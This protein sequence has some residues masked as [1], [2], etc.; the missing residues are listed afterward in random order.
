MDG[1]NEPYGGKNSDKGE[2]RGRDCSASSSHD[3]RQFRIFRGEFHG[4]SISQAILFTLVITGAVKGLPVNLVTI[5]TMDDL[6]VVDLDIGLIGAG[7]LCL[8]GS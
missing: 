3:S 4:N 6:L 8:D 1:D 2:D 5:E 7:N